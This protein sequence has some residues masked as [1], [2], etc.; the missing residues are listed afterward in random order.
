MGRVACLSGHLAFLFSDVTLCFSVGHQMV[1]CGVSGRYLSAD[2]RLSV[3]THAHQSLL[4]F[5]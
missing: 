1:S 4:T 2:N 3:S 5:G